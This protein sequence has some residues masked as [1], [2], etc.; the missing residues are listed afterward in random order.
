MKKF[1]FIAIAVLFCFWFSEVVVNATPPSIPYKIN[2]EFIEKQDLDNINITVYYGEVG[3][4]NI[5]LYRETIYT[6]SIS[7]NS[8][9]N[10]NVSEHPEHSM[11]EIFNAALSNKI[12]KCEK[13]CIVYATT[14]EDYLNSRD[15]YLYDGD[16][17]QLKKEFKLSEEMFNVE[18]GK[19]ILSFGSIRRT[20]TDGSYIYDGNVYFELDYKIE[21]GY[22]YLYGQE[23]TTSKSTMNCQ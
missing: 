2:A 19:L 3:S 18:E 12:Y 21:N 16:Y 4:S 14:Q 5:D 22:I 20:R 7:Q 1:Y 23:K 6:I 15:E 13:G 10:S 9:D 8:V 17:Y 11:D